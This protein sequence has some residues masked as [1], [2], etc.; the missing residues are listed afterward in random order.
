MPTGALLHVARLRQCTAA[1]LVLAVR[2]IVEAV[3]L[4]VELVVGGPEADEP[5]KGQDGR[6][7]V[8]PHEERVLGQAD[9]GLAERRRDG[10]HEQRDGLHQRAHVLGRLGERVLERSDRGEDLRDAAQHVRQRLHPDGDVRVLVQLLEA[11]IGLLPAGPFLVDV[12]LRHAGGDHGAARDEEPGGDALQRR[13]VDPDPAEERVHDLVH[14][15]DEDDEGER[16]QVVDDVVGDAVEAH[17][18]RLRGQVVEHLVVREPYRVSVVRIAVLSRKL[19]EGGAHTEER[20]PQEHPARFESSP[21]FVH[22]FVVKRH[23]CRLVVPEFAWLHVLPE[24]RSVHV[25]ESVFDGI[26]YLPHTVPTSAYIEQY[27]DLQ[28]DW[29]DRPPSLHSESPEPDRLGV[30]RPGWLHETVPVPAEEQDRGTE[31]E[32]DR[33]EQVRQPEAD[34]SLGVHHGDLANEGADVDHQVEVV[35]DPRDRRRR[36]DDHALAALQSLDVQSIL[37]IL[38]RD[39]G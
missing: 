8:V 23:P 25:L 12:V 32:H 7:A 6:D 34:V 1:A 28:L 20:V 30:D 19:N 16:V 4:L 18:C 22:P 14:D 5:D 31:A 37:L 36:V 39:Q 27:P 2:E 26:S 35:V 29:I 38:L 33:G 13:E 10:V 24:I 15:R 9:H 3:L 17:G 11:V 21:H